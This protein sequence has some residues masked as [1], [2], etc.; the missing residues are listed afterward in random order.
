MGILVAAER[1]LLLNASSAR[2]VDGSKSRP[3]LA[4]DRGLRIEM[5]CLRERDCASPSIFRRRRRDFADEVKVTRLLAAI[6][7]RA[8]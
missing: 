2:D 5:L 6:S 4:R 3:S 1:H 7:R 8:R